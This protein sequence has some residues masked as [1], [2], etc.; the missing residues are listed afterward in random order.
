[1]S[2]NNNKSIFVVG[3]VVTVA[4]MISATM[5]SLPAAT[6]VVYGVGGLAMYAYC[7]ETYAMFLSP[8]ESKL[9]CIHYAIFDDPRI[10]QTVCGDDPACLN[11]FVE[12]DGTLNPT[13]LLDMVNQLPMQTKQQIIAYFDQ[14]LAGMR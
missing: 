4:A 14:Q 1:M 13:R 8:L 9:N 10:I 3:A 12:P 2:Y 11:A 7:A 6:D 5:L